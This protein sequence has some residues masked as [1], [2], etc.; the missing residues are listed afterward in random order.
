VH[1]PQQAH[2]ICAGDFSNTKDRKTYCE[3]MDVS[4]GD[5]LTPRQGNSAPFKVLCTTPGYKDTVTSGL[6]SVAD[7]SLCGDDGAYVTEDPSQP[8]CFTVL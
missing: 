1:A 2:A 6:S 7:E 8:L 5:C 4:Q 3:V